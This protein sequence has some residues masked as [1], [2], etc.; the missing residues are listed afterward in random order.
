L[1]SG[2]R[3]NAFLMELNLFIC[4]IDSIRKYM[5]QSDRTIS[6]LAKWR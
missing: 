3:L 5:Q 1:R 6:L 2:F 4:F